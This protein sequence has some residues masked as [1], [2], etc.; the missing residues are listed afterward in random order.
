[1]RYSDIKNAV[2]PR[3]QKPPALKSSLAS[4]LVTVL[5]RLN[6]SL[7]RGFSCGST[8]SLV[9]TVPISAVS[10][11]RTSS[12]LCT[13]NPPFLHDMAWQMVYF[14]PQTHLLS[15]SDRGILYL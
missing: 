5:L 15:K 12:C 7:L 3:D 6:Q 8:S 13:M 1:M 14:S 4:G 9:Q 11:L 2:T 10:R